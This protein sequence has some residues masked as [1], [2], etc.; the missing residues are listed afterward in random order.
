MDN[1]YLDSQ[2]DRVEVTGNGRSFDAFYRAHHERLFRILVLSLRNPSLA[3]EALDE[4]MTRALERWDRIAS[5]DRPDYWV[6]RVAL[7]WS[8]SWWRK[9]RREAYELLVEPSAEDGLP[10]PEVAAALA[11]L[12]VKFRVVVVARLYLDWSTAVTADALG[13]PAGTVKSRLSRALRRL[14]NDLGGEQ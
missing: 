2:A 5:Y 1:A 7:N 13:I 9:T 12:P 8:T 14:A 6:L 3:G 10:D 11:R 4:A